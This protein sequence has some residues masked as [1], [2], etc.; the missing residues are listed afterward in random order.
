MNVNKLE[1]IILL[2]NIVSLIYFAILAL[3]TYY[4][5]DSNALQVVGEILTIPLFFVILLSFFYALLKLIRKEKTRNVLPIFIVS[6]ISI[7][8]LVI[9]TV[10]QLN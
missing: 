5:I 10:I 7:I 8:F 2:L 3:L 9:L 1:R 6:A 4:P